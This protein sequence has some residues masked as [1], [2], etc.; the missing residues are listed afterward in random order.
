MKIVVGIDVN[1]GN[2]VGNNTGGGSNG[3]SDSDDN[4]FTSIVI[5]PVKIAFNNFLNTLTEQQ[6]KCVQNNSS[7]TKQINLTIENNLNQNLDINDTSFDFI[8]QAVEAVC[9]RG[10]NIDNIDFEDKIINE[11]TGKEKCVYD[12]LKK[13]NLFKST[14]NKFENSTDYNLTIKNGNCYNT[15]TACTDGNDIN[16]G[17]ITIIMEIVAGNFPLEYAATL[18]HEGVHAELFK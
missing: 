12:K 7:L 17:N 18:L 6:K 8:N 10:I 15:N 4:F 5:S 13:L 11:L 9:D 16:N 14:I 1:F 3:P 2:N